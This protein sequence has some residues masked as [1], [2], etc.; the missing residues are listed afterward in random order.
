MPMFHFYA[1][2][3]VKRAECNTGG[4]WIKF[5]ISCKLY[6]IFRTPVFI[7][8]LRWLLLNNAS[9][10]LSMR[11]PHNLLVPRFSLPIYI[12]TYSMPISRSIEREYWLEIAWEILNSIF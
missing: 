4:K 6:E 1:P 8:H 10:V 11:K 2:E 3:N 12:L 5:M 7:E 9:K